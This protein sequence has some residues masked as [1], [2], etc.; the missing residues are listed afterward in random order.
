MTVVALSAAYGAGGS[1][2]GPTLAKRLGVPFV[3]RAIPL[4]V[5]Q[6]LDVDVPTAQEHDEQLGGGLVKRM[7]SGFVSHDASAP[8]PL[9]PELTVGEDFRRATEEVLLT[10]AQTGEGVILGR[11]A[12]IVLRGRPGVLRARLEGPA[13]RRSAQAARLGGISLE[14]ADEARRRVDRAQAAYWSR[15][16]GAEISD[17][18]LYHLVIDSTA[19][20]LEACIELLA[21]AARSL[22]PT[23]LRTGNV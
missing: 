1:Q 19:I 15:F 7:L 4:G 21:L 12:V 18:S 3:D 20:E 22:A 10:Q 23:D 9:P 16:Y 11:A 13:E 6:R 14:Q 2:V 5:A 17:P 8:A